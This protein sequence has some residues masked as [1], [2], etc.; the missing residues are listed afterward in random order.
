LTSA[1]VGMTRARMSTA[2][3]VD[4]QGDGKY[5][6]VVVEGGSR[7]T[8]TVTVEEEYHRKLTGG[9]IAP[10]ELVRRSFEFL[11]EHEPKESILGS[12]GLPVIGRY[13]PAYE[14]EMR[15]RLGG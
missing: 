3:T 14:G 7:T 5:R 8:H 11:L 10:E 6:V 15:R 9:R 4:L 2:I 1:Q 13:F 12:F